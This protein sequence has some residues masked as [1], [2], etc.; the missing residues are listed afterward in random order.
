MPTWNCAHRMLADV[1][2]AVPVLLL[3]LGPPKTDCRH[4]SHHM[5]TIHHWHFN[6]QRTRACTVNGSTSK[7]VLASATALCGI[8]CYCM[9]QDTM[10]TLSH[11]NDRGLQTDR[12]QHTV[13]DWCVYVLIAHPTPI[14]SINVAPKKVPVDTQQPNTCCRLLMNHPVVVAAVTAHYCLSCGFYQCR[15]CPEDMVPQD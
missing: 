5:L 2:P 4:T 7:N 12:I 11:I 8:V 9:A 15:R 6:T 14:V 3:I 1:A 10:Q 13:Q